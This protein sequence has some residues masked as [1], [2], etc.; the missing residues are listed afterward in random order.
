M[1]KGSGVAIVTPFTEDGVN[2]EKLGELIEF[3]ISEKTDAL[4]ICGTT[5][6]A[7]TM[8]DSEH[9]ETIKY[10]VEKVNGRIPVIAGTGSNDTK[11]CIEL[12]K[13][14]EDVGADGL[15]VVTPYYNKANRN[16]LI[17]HFTEVANAVTIPIMLYNVPSR[18]NLNIDPQMLKTLSEVENIVAIKEASGNLAQVSEMAA[19]CGDKIA[20]YS[21]NDDIIL[22]VLSVGGLGVVSVA[23]NIVP[24]TI[25][26]LVMS[27]LNG[28]IEQSRNLQL[29]TLKLINALFIE[30]NPI[31]VKTALNLL[32][33]NV[34]KLR[35]PLS[36]MSDNNLEYLK[37][38][39]GEYGFEV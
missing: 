23:A 27:F 19:L 8:P 7:S 5:G 14:A 37:Q 36:E 9:K 16:G 10:T 26:D 1:F 17:K 31:P 29:K 20:L 6:E 12:S 25:H 15:L 18:T 32:G 24:R 30:V 13:Y 39:L 34:G 38:T 2:F 35:M 33:Y 28:D 4:I 11:H 22:P 3:Q 21:G